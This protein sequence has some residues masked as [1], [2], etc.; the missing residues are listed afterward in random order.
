MR[1]KQFKVWAFKSI[2]P[3]L[4]WA[5]P[6]T[7]SVTL[8]GNSQ[9]LRNE[10]PC[11]LKGNDVSLQ[12][13]GRL[14]WEEAYKAFLSISFTPILGLQQKVEFLTLYNKICWGIKDPTSPIL[15]ISTLYSLCIFFFI[16]NSVALP[17]NIFDNQMIMT[18]KRNYIP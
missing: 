2:K 10:F 6:L 15:P 13:V 9:T 1:D 17:G 5:L 18:I 4:V 14:A 3:G 11:L 8:P 12:V 7:S 16:I